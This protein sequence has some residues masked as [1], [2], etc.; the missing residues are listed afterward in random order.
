M[1]N[2]TPHR[3]D[4]EN[5][6][7]ISRDND[8]DDID[9]FQTLPPYTPRTAAKRA[10]DF[11][12]RSKINPGRN[13]TMQFQDL[14]EEEK[15]QEKTLVKSSF[16]IFEDDDDDDDEEDE[17]DTMKNDNNNPF[18][19]GSESPTTRPIMRRAKTLDIFDDSLE[20]PR[21]EFP[22]LEFDPVNMEDSDS[23]GDMN[24]FT[25]ASA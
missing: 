25:R 5:E 23:D 9:K 3:D 13:L 11:I 4:D 12:D 17:F 24:S 21:L 10:K 2:N 8:N 6:F 16:N 15:K 18:L 14:L 1:M 20:F 22:H 19:N 7:S